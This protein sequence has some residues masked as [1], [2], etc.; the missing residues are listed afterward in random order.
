MR[1]EPK[2]VTSRVTA[3]VFGPDEWKNYPHLIAP[4]PPLSE[5]WAMERPR[6][7]SRRPPPPPEIVRREKVNEI[8]PL[9]R[10]YPRAKPIGIR[11]G[12]LPS[13]EKRRVPHQEKKFTFR[14]P[15]EIE[16]HPERK[17]KS[18]I[19]R[20]VE[21]API[22]PVTFRVAPRFSQIPSL[23]SP[24][25]ERRPPP[26]ITNRVVAPSL[27]ECDKCGAK[28]ISG[29]THVCT[30]CS[31]ETLSQFLHESRNLFRKEALFRELQLPDNERGYRD[32]LAMLDF[33][34][35]PE[36]R[37]H[38]LTSPIDKT[39]ARLSAYL[40]QNQRKNKDRYVI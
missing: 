23:P 21:E 22:V 32:L 37:I 16:V 17:M 19:P 26:R 24:K 8:P 34:R 14:V 28:E 12:H 39:C 11:T 5:R 38:R 7:Q 4:A 27:D 3:P 1:K 10:V 20:E 30:R 15:R 6:G 31:E 40:R 18:R 33:G 29:T 36:A 9:E 13:P 25:F 35:E 2:N